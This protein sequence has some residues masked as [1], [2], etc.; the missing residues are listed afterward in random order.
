MMKSTLAIVA[1]IIMLFPIVT[2]AQRPVGKNVNNMHGK[3]ADDKSS[4]FNLGYYYQYGI[5]RPKNRELAMDYYR[6]S[7]LDGDE[8]AMNNLGILYH[9]AGGKMN[10]SLAEYW[11]SQSANAG[12]A[13]GICNLGMC[14]EDGI[15]VTRNVKKALELYRKSAAAGYKS[16]ITQLG[17]LYEKGAE[18]IPRNYDSS[19]YWY[20]KGSNLGDSMATQYVGL[21]YENGHGVAQNYNMAMK[22]Y[23]LA[24]DQHNYDA[25]NS[26][27]YM[28]NNG[29]GV[30]KDAKTALKWYEKAAKSNNAAALNNIAIFY[31]EGSAGLTKDPQKAIGLFQSSITYGYLDAMYNLAN[32]YLGDDNYLN[33]TAAYDLL[34]AAADKLNPPSTAKFIELENKWRG[35]ASHKELITS[36]LKNAEN[37]NA[38]AMNYIAVCYME[39]NYFAKDVDQSTKWLKKA[40]ALGNANAIKNLGLIYYSKDDY[41]PAMKLFFESFYAGEISS[42]ILI[43]E[44]FENGVGVKKDI[45]RAAKWYQ[46]NIDGGYIAGKTCLGKLILEQSVPNYSRENGIK[47]LKDAAAAGDESA[48]KILLKYDIH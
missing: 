28:Y 3:A 29:M 35:K 27:G 26:I 40:A 39:G 34:L 33:D 47:L 21:L 17:I 11:F 31:L 18:D 45:N 43:G 32:V 15:A 48:K 12:D 30:K 7:I 10:D 20:L 14:Y 37:G 13:R 19:M 16:A 23:L 36:L 24:A 44:M 46:R 2:T 1:F 41:G 38:F 5:E 22:W 25:M 6:K 8:R 4:L 9:E 42:A